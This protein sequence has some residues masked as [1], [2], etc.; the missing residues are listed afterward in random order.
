MWFPEEV[1]VARGLSRRPL[2][3]TDQRGGAAIFRAVNHGH[4]QRVAARSGS[5]SALL[6]RIGVLVGGGQEQKSPR[7]FKFLA[8]RLTTQ[9][10]TFG[11]PQG[12]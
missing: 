1:I 12:G 2:G 8:D 6:E 10:C 3:E 7:V 5:F 4:A 9:N 11:Q